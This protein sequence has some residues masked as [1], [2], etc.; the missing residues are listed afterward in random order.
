MNYKNISLAG[1]KLVSTYTSTLLQ[2]Y[3]LSFPLF[4]CLGTY[5]T[6]SHL[7]EAAASLS[8]T[9]FGKVSCNQERN[10][11]T[12]LHHERAIRSREILRSKEMY[13]RHNFIRVYRDLQEEQNLMAEKALQ[14]DRVGKQ[15]TACIAEENHILA[16]IQDFSCTLS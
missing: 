6:S 13:L 9:R 8:I 15:H 11:H 12:H 10:F 5:L 2:E 3:S 4:N 14:C 1:V 16:L 7:T